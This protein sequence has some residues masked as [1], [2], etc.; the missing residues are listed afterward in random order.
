MLQ[1]EVD[2]NHRRRHK[3]GRIDEF[4][5]SVLD[6]V[7]LLVW[8]K[9]RYGSR[10]VL[11]TGLGPS[12]IVLLHMCRR[13]GLEIPVFFL[14]TGYHFPE[15]YEFKQRIEEFLNLSIV[16]LRS[17]SGTAS[18]SGF[19]IHP[20][21]DGVERC[22]DM[23]KVR[24]LTRYL[25]D[26]DAWITGIR[27]DQGPTRASIDAVEWDDA[28]NLRKLAP[29]A[30]WTRGRVWEYIR[31]HRLPTNPLH[32][33][34]YPS[35]GCSPCTIPAADCGDDERA[36]RWSGSTKTECGIHLR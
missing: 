17:G 18:E 23:R 30:Y 26:K 16:S 32:A 2:D 5:S 8:A 22:C 11:G 10:V 13:A 21:V 24:P 3:A 20:E 36:G 25:R 9:K 14:D 19:A 6:P 15:T 1:I 35:I 28:N 31:K 7:K 12:G 29:L 4:N 34:G 27:R 33:A